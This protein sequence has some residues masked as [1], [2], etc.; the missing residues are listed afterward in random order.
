MRHVSCALYRERDR[1]RE[2]RL[3]RHRGGPAAAASC[4]PIVSAPAVPAVPPRTVAAVG[5]A[6]QQPRPIDLMRRRATGQPLSGHPSARRQR[7]RWR[8]AGAATCGTWRG[9][10]RELLLCTRKPS[11]GAIIDRQGADGCQRRVGRRGRCM[12]EAGLREERARTP[13][14]S[15]ASRRRMEVDGSAGM[16]ME[17]SESMDI[18]E[19]FFSH[20]CEGPGWGR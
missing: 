6:P 3:D 12:Q 8:R 11:D 13:E 2:R 5:G 14:P 17:V 9:C 15:G 18:V 16:R 10:S 4:W 1:G 7:R 19:R 20:T